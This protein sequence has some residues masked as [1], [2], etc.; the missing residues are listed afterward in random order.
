MKLIFFFNEMMESIHVRTE[1]YILFAWK[2]N[3][4]LVIT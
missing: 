1:I 3:E 4:A 2:P